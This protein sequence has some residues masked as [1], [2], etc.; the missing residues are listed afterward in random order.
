MALSNAIM[1]Y[2]D[3]KEF[4]ERA[5]DEEEGA[6]IP[7]RPEREAEYWRMRCNQFRSLD[8]RQNQMVFELGHKMHGQ[9]EYDGLTMVIKQSQD[10]YVWVYA[11]KRVLEPGLIENL[12]GIK[13]VPR[14]KADEVRMLE[15]HSDGN[16]TS[17]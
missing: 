12:S 4:L 3:C 10:G 16:E 2:Q 5:I 1:A 17:S 14:L 9:S 7:F 8:R 13:D 6:R 11:E 15:D